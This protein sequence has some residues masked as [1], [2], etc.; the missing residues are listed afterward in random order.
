MLTLADTMIDLKL[1]ILLVAPKDKGYSFL[2]KM[3]EKWLKEIEFTST[4]QPSKPIRK[5]EKNSRCNVH[6]TW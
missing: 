4:N 5:R 2:G 6:G 3:M 1:P